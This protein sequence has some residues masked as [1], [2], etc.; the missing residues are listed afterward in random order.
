MRD[1]ADASRCIK[2]SARSQSALITQGSRVPPRQQSIRGRTGR[3]NI[4]ARFPFTSIAST[5]SR[6]MSRISSTM[7]PA[8]L[9]VAAVLPGRVAQVRDL[10]APPVH[11]VR[12]EPGASGRRSGD[13]AAASRSR[14]GGRSRQFTAMVRVGG[15]GAVSSSRPSWAPIVHPGKSETRCGRGPTAEYVGRRSAC[16]AIRDNLATRRSATTLSR[17][18]VP[19][20]V[21][22]H[23][24]C[25]H[26]DCHAGHGGQGDPKGRNPRAGHRA[27]GVAGRSQHEMA[28]NDRATRDP[29]GV[30]NDSEVR[31]HAVCCPY[32]SIARRWEE[33]GTVPLQCLRISSPP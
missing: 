31:S 22:Y 16:H 3:V 23:G 20:R 5:P 15:D 11:H 13:P 8:G 17:S 6:S 25:H 32:A 2:W 12:V 7:F 28:L 26:V 30:S 24:P 14:R 29:I 27:L 1:G 9:G 21:E 18:I 19:L 4:A 10:H 33:T